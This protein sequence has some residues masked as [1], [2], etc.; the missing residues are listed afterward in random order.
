MMDIKKSAKAGQMVGLPGTCF[1]R[2][3]VHRLNESYSSLQ[4]RS[5]PRILFEPA[6]TS[7]SSRR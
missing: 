2:P 1:R 4:P 3:D 6:D 5:K 7:R